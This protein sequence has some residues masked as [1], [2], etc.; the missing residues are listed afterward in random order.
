MKKRD[1]SASPPAS[2]VKQSPPQEGSDTKES[3]SKRENSSGYDIDEI[4][5]QLRDDM[6]KA[7]IA[8]T[9]VAHLASI[10]SIFNVL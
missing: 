2:T 4:V 7:M 9:E 5:N 3:E 8:L 1:K 10:H 6:E